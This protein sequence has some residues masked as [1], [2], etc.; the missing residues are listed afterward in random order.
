MIRRVFVP[1]DIIVG[2]PGIGLCELPAP[3]SPEQ[4]ALAVEL[5]DLAR[6]TGAPLWMLLEAR[7]SVRMSRR[8]DDEGE[9]THAVE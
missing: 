4:V 8:D 6:A 1:Q 9:G 7:A 2:W 3:I 5:G